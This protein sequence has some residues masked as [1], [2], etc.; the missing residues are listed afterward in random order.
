MPRPD[1][2]ATRDFTYNTRRLKAGDSFQARNSDDALILTRLLGKATY[3]RP[4]GTVA[5]P[6]PEVVEQMVHIPTI[7]EVLE[8]KVIEPKKAPAKR[9]RRAKARK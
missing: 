3:G 8:A 5:P 7:K 4:I 6:P 9:K 1:L 2:I